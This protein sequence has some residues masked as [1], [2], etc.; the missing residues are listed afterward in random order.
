[1][2]CS[3]TLSV[4]LPRTR[5][6]TCAG[7]GRGAPTG[8]GPLQVRSLPGA[9][10]QAGGSQTP[11]PTGK[12]EAAAPTPAMPSHE[13]KMAPTTEHRNAADKAKSL[14]LPSLP[15]DDSTELKRKVSASPTAAQTKTQ[16]GPC[17]LAVGLQAPHTMESLGMHKDTL[18]FSSAV[19][20]SLGSPTHSNA[21]G[22]VASPPHSLALWSDMGDKWPATPAAHTPP[23]SPLSAVPSC[24]QGLTSTYPSMPSMGTCAPYVL[25][26]QDQGA[27]AELR[28]S[29][30]TS[31]HYSH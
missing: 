1:M 25:F 21:G 7:H 9:I 14:A 10:E 20:A 31:S 19:S 24:S 5:S 17:T 16:G 23:T 29:Q 28:G 8:S 11:G 13:A 27:L 3:K 15:T 4:S 30:F 12:A 22:V 26:S 2:G 6:T 18:S